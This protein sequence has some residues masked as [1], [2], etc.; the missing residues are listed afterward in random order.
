MEKFYA[1][2]ETKGKIIGS[3]SAETL[4]EAEKL[5]IQKYGEYGEEMKAITD[6]KCNKNVTAMA[7]ENLEE[8][9]AR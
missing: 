1:F 4:D 6:G 8:I 9:S 5:I 7:K 3:V 2:E